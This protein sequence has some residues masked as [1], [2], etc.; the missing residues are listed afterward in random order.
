MSCS[1]QNKIYEISVERINESFIEGIK[2]ST[3]IKMGIAHVACNGVCVCV[4]PSGC[5]VSVEE[6][7]RKIRM[8][9]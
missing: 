3:E 7:L 5:R 8:K 9:I 1:N 4:C 2:E 6:K